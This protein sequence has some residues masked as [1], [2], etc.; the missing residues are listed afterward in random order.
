[1]IGQTNHQVLRRVT[2]CSELASAKLQALDAYWRTKKGDRALPSW[3]DIDPGELGS[4]LPHLIVAGIEHDPLRV[5]Y[6]LAGTQIVE[7]RGEIT[8]HYL[9]QIPWS[10]PVGQATTQEGF[11]RVVA[12]RAPLFSEVD[13]TTRTGAMH[14]ILTGIWPLATTPS[15]PIDRCLALEDY[16]D[17]SVGDLA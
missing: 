7:F 10:S 2:D 16:G 14:R 8:G 9:Q 5:F 4:L 1:M 17:L 15:A 12:S 13:I 6:R 3:S 11:A